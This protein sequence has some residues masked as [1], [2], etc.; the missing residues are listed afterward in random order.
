MISASDN[1]GV[2]SQ[3]KELLRQ[4]Q[5]RVNIAISGSLQQ[6]ADRQKCSFLHALLWAL[7]GNVCVSLLVYLLD[8]LLSTD[9]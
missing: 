5:S 4:M 1:D 8:M 2:T 7:V 9:I 3:P 6:A